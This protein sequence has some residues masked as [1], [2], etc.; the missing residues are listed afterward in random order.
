M[1]LFICC[2]LLLASCAGVQAKELE[3]VMVQETVVMDDGRELHLNGAGVR[4]KFFFDIYVIAL[5]LEHQVNTVD[6][7]LAEDGRK[8]VAMHFLYDKVERDKLVAAWDEGFVGNTGAGEL[9]VLQPR[10]EQFNSLFRDAVKGDIIILDYVPGIGT[11][12]LINNEEQ[13]V[14]PGKD[15]NDALLRIWLGEKPVTKDLKKEL[16][17]GL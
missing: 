11:K 6:Q 1:R 13:G 3:G 12:V 10:I 17:A 15:F 16:L 2:C 8:R 9:R 7:V 14:T 4:S 5:Y